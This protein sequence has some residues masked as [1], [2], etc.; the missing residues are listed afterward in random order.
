MRRTPFHEHLKAKGAVFGELAGWERANWYAREGQERDYRY[1]WKRQNWFENS[2]AEHR[3]VRT[4]VGM[5]DM[6]PF[7]KLRVEGRDAEAFLNHVCGNDMAVEPGRIV[8]TQFLNAK[9]G[10]EADVTVTR[11]SE[12][13]Y[14]VVTPTITRVADEVWLRRHAGDFQVVITDVTA[15]EGVLA[16]MGP[17]ARDLL[18][19]VSPNDFSNEA[20][21]SARCGRSRSAWASPAPIAS[22]M[23]ASWVG[24]SMFRPTWPAMFLKHWLR[25]V[26]ITASPFAACI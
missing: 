4:G 23:S 24:N 25:R 3:A 14:L 26:R 22:P 5:Y 17:K 16:V 9:G 18:R 1:S 2:A 10:I 8:Y 20:H 11:L 7:G 13:V 12:T 15:G 21:P 6:S 19:A